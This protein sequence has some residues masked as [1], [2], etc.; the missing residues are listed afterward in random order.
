MS[1]RLKQI[2]LNSN[3]PPLYKRRWFWLVVS[4]VALM[5]FCVGIAYSK[6]ASVV[7]IQQSTVNSKN[8]LISEDEYKNNCQSID[9]KTLARNPDKYN[10]NDYVFTGKVIQT[11]ES[12]KSDTVELRIN[13]TQD[14]YSWSDTI[15]ATVEIP[16]GNNRILD[17]DVIKFWGRCAGLHSYTG[18][19]GSNVSLPQID[20][21][22][23]EIAE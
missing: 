14:E 15:Y 9:Y 22:Y 11:Q 12:T 21:R 23:F 1:N 16:K 2:D 5:F 20:I 19:L 4:L 3:K 7:Q 13:I 18:A 10:G 6:N 8:G 17:D